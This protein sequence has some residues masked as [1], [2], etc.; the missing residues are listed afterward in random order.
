MSVCLSVCLDMPVHISDPHGCVCVCRL[1]RAFIDYPD[2][3]AFP[4]FIG[5]ATFFDV[6]AETK[7][8]PK[9]PMDKLIIFQSSGVEK[10][11][12]PQNL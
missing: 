6:M 12:H 2:K 7:F 3:V 11:P 10:A 9:V 5:V 8:E 4:Y 1:A